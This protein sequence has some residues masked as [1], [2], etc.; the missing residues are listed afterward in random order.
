MVH[1]EN[2]G[3]FKGRVYESSDHTLGRRLSIVVPHLYPDLENSSRGDYHL[4]NNSDGNG[5][6][7]MWHTDKAAEPTVQQLADAKEPA[8]DA[9]WWW[10]LRRKRDKLLVKSDWSRGAD[11]PSA[12]KSSYITYREAL[13]NLPSTVI[14][15]SFAIM[16]AQSINTAHVELLEQ[17]PEKPS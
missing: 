7:L 14:K 10:W 3:R 16:N 1:T 17:F 4:Q 13:R 6:Q 5:T 11:V 12:L 8:M 2:D 15:P 9:H